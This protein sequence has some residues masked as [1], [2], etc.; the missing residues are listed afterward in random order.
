M[1]GERIEGDAY[2]ASYAR[3]AYK[4]QKEY[5]NGAFHDFSYQPS[6]ISR[7]LGLDGTDSYRLYG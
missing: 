3:Q 1:E 7:Q 6:A 4:R 2:G 5:G